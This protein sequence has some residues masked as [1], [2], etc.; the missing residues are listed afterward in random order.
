MEPPASRS[1]RFVYKFASSQQAFH[2]PDMH[3]I[4]EAE[5]GEAAQ[6]LAAEL[7][8]RVRL[9]DVKMPGSDRARSGRIPVPNVLCGVSGYMDKNIRDEQRLAG[10]RRAASADPSIPGE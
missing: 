7:Q 8:P 4:G 1:G 10:I 6:K 2:P 5:E 3:V 9:P